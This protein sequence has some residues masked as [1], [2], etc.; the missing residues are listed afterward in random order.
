MKTLDAIFGQGK[1]RHEKAEREYAH[2]EIEALKVPFSR[3]VYKLKEDIDAGTYDM[4]IGD[5][6]SGRIP[7]MA[8]RKVF[9]NRMRATHPDITPDEDREALKTYFVA[10]GRSRH[11]DQYEHMRS[12]FEKIAPEV[13]RRALVVTEYIQSGESIRRLVKLLD[14]EHIPFDIAT[15]SFG[16]DERDERS[17]EVRD[18]FRNHTIIA[19][20]V[21][22]NAGAPLIYDRQDLAG[23]EKSVQPLNAHA[24]RYFE[25][26]SQDFLAAR[27]DISRLADEALKENWNA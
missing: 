17:E 18:F 7:T 21:T 9:A 12:F 5:D 23:V 22:R 13:R 19:G 20:I 8:L 16:I 3:L 26:N 24:V 1:K 10:G 6:A 25:K 14:A 15:I 4:L 27:G 11:E 2:A